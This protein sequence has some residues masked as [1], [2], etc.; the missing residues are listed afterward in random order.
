MK[1]AYRVKHEG[2]NNNLIDLIIE[3]KAF[4]MLKKEEILSILDPMNFV[5]RAPEQVVEFVEEYL[6]P[7]IADYKDCI[8][9]EVD[10][11]V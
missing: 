1:A 9:L 3:D 4:N 8:G 7:A 2:L 6:E 11:K 10:L 5:G